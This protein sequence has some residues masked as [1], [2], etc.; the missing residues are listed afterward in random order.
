MLDC[1]MGASKPTRI[2]GC[3]V[4]DREIESIL[5]FVK[6][7][8]GTEYSDTVMEGIQQHIVLEKGAKKGRASDDE[9]GGGDEMLPQATEAVVEA[10]F[11]SVTL[12]KR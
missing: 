4:T 7:Q 3:F 9:E 1:P 2:Q 6:E 5:A 11:A 10:G 8:S 12:Q